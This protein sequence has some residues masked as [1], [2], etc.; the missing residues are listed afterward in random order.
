[1]APWKNTTVVF[2]Q[3][4]KTKPEVDP[5]K[6]I[7]LSFIFHIPFKSI[8]G[9]GSK[10]MAAFFQKT[11]CVKI[12]LCIITNQKTRNIFSHYPLSAALQYKGNITG[13][14]LNMWI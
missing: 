4:F 10:K 11:L 14:A 6:S 8:T 5:P 9:F 12:P 1:M 3:F 2:V 7:I 13:N